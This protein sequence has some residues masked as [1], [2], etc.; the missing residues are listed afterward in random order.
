MFPLVQKPS[1]LLILIALLGKVYAYVPALPSNQ[2]DSSSAGI[3]GR[4]YVYVYNVTTPTSITLRSAV[5]PPNYSGL[6]VVG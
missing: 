4:L 6:G 2:T 3:E 5:V 1:T